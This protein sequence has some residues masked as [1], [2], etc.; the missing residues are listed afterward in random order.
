MVFGVFAQRAC[1][2]PRRYFS[3]CGPRRHRPGSEGLPGNTITSPQGCFGLGR[4]R[5][6]AGS[7][8]AG[9]D[10]SSPSRAQIA[11]STRARR[12]FSALIASLGDT[13]A[14]AC[15]KWAYSSHAPEALVGKCGVCSGF[16]TRARR[17]ESSSAAPPSG[18]SSCPISACD[19]PESISVCGRA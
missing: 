7:F 13:M 2:Q 19:L 12:R 6:S 17:L 3:G 18:S 9:S 1:T 5:F 8:T 11:A 4:P 16:R 14:P 15:V 10:R